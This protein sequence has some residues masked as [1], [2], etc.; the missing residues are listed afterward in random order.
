MKWPHL[1]VIGAALG[2]AGMQQSEP[3]AAPQTPPPAAPAAP[4]A[5][6]P[7]PP[8]AVVDVPKPVAETPAPFAAVEITTATGW[9]TFHGNNERTG[10]S[11][12]TPIKRPKLR[13]SAKVG[14]QGYLNTPLAV[15]KHVVIVPSSG[16]AHNTPDPDDG[17]YALDLASGRRLWHAHF[18]QDA[19]GASATESRVFAT[20]DDGHVYAINIRTGKVVWKQQGKGKMYTHPL[21]VAGQVVVGDATGWVY[22]F[23]IQAGKLR[24]KIQLTGAIRGG[25]AADSQR[26]Y[27]ASQG[28]EVA[29]FTHQ[30]RKVWR[31]MVKR[32][33]W[34][35]GGVAVAIEAYSPPIVTR[36][37]LIIPF[38][39]D[40]YYKDVP[41]LL[42]LNKNTGRGRWRAKGPGQWGNV[43]VTPSLLQGKLV[44]A[45]PYSSDI[46]AISAASGRSAYR[47]PAGA[48]LFPSWASP[49]AAGD[50]VYVPRFDG[51]LYAVRVGSG[52]I[53]WDLYLGDKAHA[54]RSKPRWPKSKYGCDWKVPKGYSIYSPVGIAEDGT[55]LVG[56]AEG[57]LYAITES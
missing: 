34:G 36:D 7:G 25:A 27:V 51:S 42:A 30:G 33:P 39:R 55:V 5:P 44:Y 14:I 28:G 43:R 2:C 52:K 29:A 12:A 13:W 32:P 38:A 8:N 26:I 24:W 1:L 48:C 37:S 31:K 45:E 3:G 4:A 20:S 41:A 49:A 50:V 22:S 18:D 46:V 16:R 9:V 21:L 11:S 23:G 57:Y 40:T 15:G 19:N 10:V 54:G 17:V 56:T 47:K 35:G 53:L 6:P